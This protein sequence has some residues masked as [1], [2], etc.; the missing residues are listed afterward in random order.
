MFI[1][2]WSEFSGSGWLSRLSMD[3]EE[4]LDCVLARIFCLVDL[5]YMVMYK[6]RKLTKRGF[7]GLQWTE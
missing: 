3:W 2:F 6:T 4:K 5:V 7:V 1:N